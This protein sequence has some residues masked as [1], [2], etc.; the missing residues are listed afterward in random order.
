MKKILCKIGIHF[1]SLKFI[2]FADQPFMTGKV[3]DE[4]CCLES[5]HMYICKCECG[6]DYRN[7][8]NR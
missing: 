3:E 1:Y 2:P 8:L 7:L 5:R 6:K 4:L